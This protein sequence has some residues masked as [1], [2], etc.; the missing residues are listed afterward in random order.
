VE[1]LEI[2]LSRREGKS[3]MYSDCIET[4]HKNWQTLEEEGAYYY[5]YWHLPD[6]IIRKLVYQTTDFSGIS[7][8]SVASHTKTTFLSIFIKKLQ[9]HNKHKQDAQLSQR[10]RAAVCVIVFAK[11]RTLELGDNDLRTL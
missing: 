2:I 10:D 5:Y 3:A 8:I 1:R 11:S 6:R 7:Y 9:F 4:L